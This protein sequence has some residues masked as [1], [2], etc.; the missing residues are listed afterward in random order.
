MYGLMTLSNHIAV[1]SVTIVR[2]YGESL[3]SL[4]YTKVRDAYV[5]KSNAW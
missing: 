4:T 2:D 3:E 5:I 1:N